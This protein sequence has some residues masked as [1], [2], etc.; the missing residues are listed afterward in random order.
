MKKSVVL[1]VVALAL[2]ACTGNKKQAEAATT[3]FELEQLLAVAD[4]NVDATV[5]VVGYVTHTCMH[6]GKKCFIVGE[7][8]NV[9]LQVMAAG[10]IETF[11]AD[12]VGSKLAITGTLKQQHVSEESINELETSVKALENEEGMAEECATELSNISDMRQ[13][14]KDHGKDYYVMYYMNGEKYD[15]LD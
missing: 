8:Q 5:T 7:S 11:S 9:S 15:I 14:M 4:Q 1:L 3:S 6:S 13:W 2:C 12:L 10:E